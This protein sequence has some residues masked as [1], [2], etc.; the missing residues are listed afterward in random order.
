MAIEH[1][2]LENQG[3]GDWPAACHEKSDPVATCESSSRQRMEVAMHNRLLE[4]SPETEMFD[5]E[6]IEWATEAETGVLQET[7]E[8]GLAL[9][10]LA[11][12]SDRGLNHFIT[13]LIRSVLRQTAHAFDPSMFNAIFGVL[14][15]MTKVIL[16]IAGGAH[17]ASVGQ[18]LA[19]VASRL[20][21]LEL[22][23]L[24][25]EDREFQAARRCVRFLSEA[26]VNAVVVK[27]GDPL[28]AARKATTTAAQRYAPGLV[29]LL[30]MRNC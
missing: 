20:F 8:I 15:R 12:G 22:E 21:A 11:V 1:P 29:T 25:N 14:S 17:R 10:L 23:G 27:A 6:N 24:S 4:Y 26:I 9:E 30:S 2:I 5:A 19:R 18:R 28:A 3:V 13:K 16:R 7:E